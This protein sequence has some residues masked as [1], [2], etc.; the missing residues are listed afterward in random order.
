MWKELWRILREGESLL[1]EARIETLEMLDHGKAMFDV[2]LKAMVGEVGE[3]V[4]DEIARMDRVLNESQKAVRKK[5]VRKKA[6]RKKATRK[7]AGRK[8]APRKSTTATRFV[9]ELVTNAHR[10]SGEIA[11]PVGSGKQRFGSSNST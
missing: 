6:T 4:L 8:A 9:P 3:D 11:T 10:P 2:I 5:A 7:T 1:D